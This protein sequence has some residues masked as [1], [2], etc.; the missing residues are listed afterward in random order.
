MLQ[1]KKVYTLSEFCRVLKESQEFKA[2]KGKNVESEDKKNNEKAVNDILKQG[3]KFDGGLSDEKKKEN[4][5]DITD[6]NKT[7]LD[8]DFAYEPSKEYKDRVKAQVHGFP[9]VENEKNSK[10]EEENDSLDFEG[11]KDFYEQNAEK[12]K[13]VAD[14]RQTDKHAGLKSHNLP[15]ETFKDNTLYTNES[16]KMKR[17]NFS[18]TVFLN[19]AEMIKKIPDDMKIDGNKF[20]MKDAVGNEY[21]VEC[22]KDKAIN[23][24]I[25]TKVVDYKNKEKIDETFKRM[26]ELYGYKSSTGTQNS[27]KFENGMVG[28]MISESKEKLFIKNED[29]KER[30]FKTLIESQK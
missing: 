12:R 22:V 29:T 2:R 20:Y 24:I 21:L 5:R 1:E 13:K 25:H 17:L 15:K 26:K 6:Y 14:A 3:K 23:D 4:P 10:I 11:N 18:K 9:S 7:T 8:N 27:G 28:K 19:E 16:R 30:F